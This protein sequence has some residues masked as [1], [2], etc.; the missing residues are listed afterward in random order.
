MSD[1]LLPCPFCGAAPAGYSGP[2]RIPYIGV[3]VVSEEKGDSVVV[4]GTCGSNG[5]YERTREDAIKAWNTRSSP[6]SASGTP[7]MNEHAEPADTQELEII[8]KMIQHG[9]SAKLSSEYTW[10]DYMM[11]LYKIATSRNQE[12]GDIDLRKLAEETHGALLKNRE[13]V[14]GGYYYAK[15]P[16]DIIH[17]ALLKAAGRKE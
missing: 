2:D 16:V 9:Q 5:S 6:A 11:D 8:S 7:I 14:I 17:A 10:E 13:L 12:R 4:C 1:E 3:E 15:S